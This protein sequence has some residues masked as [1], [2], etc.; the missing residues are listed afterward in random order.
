MSST[1]GISGITI[2]LIFASNA[3]AVVL[4]MQ[5]QISF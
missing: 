2:F 3:E 4:P 1:V 5:K